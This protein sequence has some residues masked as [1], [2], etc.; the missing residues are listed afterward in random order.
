MV[1]VPWTP[2]VIPNVPF[3]LSDW[4][5]SWVALSSEIVSVAEPPVTV[6]AW[7]TVALSPEF[8]HIYVYVQVT[9]CTPVAWNWK[10]SARLL[11]WGWY[12]ASGPVLL[13]QAATIMQMMK[14]AT[15][16]RRRETIISGT[17][18]VRVRTQ[19]KARQM[20]STRDA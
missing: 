5:Y 16:L 10:L 15:R 7:F 18:R 12:G 3:A 2:L 17:P 14:A 11:I 13:P 20:P 1:Q 4:E 6:V 9:F 19:D 8:A